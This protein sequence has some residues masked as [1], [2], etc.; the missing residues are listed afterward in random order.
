MIK[1]AMPKVFTANF[2]TGFRHDA[3]CFDKDFFDEF[4]R[5]DS[6][7]GSHPGYPEN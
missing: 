6:E 5:Y 3:L 2:H 4:V 1:K 7:Y